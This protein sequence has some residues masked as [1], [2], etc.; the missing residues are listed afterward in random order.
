M[1]WDGAALAA[2]EAAL[3]SSRLPA[4]QKAL[5][6]I[7]YRSLFHFASILAK[8]DSFVFLPQVLPERG[9]VCTDVQRYAAE[10]LDSS[11]VHGLIGLGGGLTPAGDDFLVGVLAVLRWLDC[12]EWEARL[13]SE[14]ARRLGKTTL[15]SSAFLD[16]ALEGEFSQ[17]VLDLFEAIGNDSEAVLAPAV[18]RLCTVGHTSGSDLLGGVLWTLNQITKQEG[19]K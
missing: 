18:S 5:D 7:P 9:H 3:Y 15:I 8:P 11:G 13:S 14:I 10:V 2:R 17:P 16:R 19:H 6:Q 4:A 12:R 1:F